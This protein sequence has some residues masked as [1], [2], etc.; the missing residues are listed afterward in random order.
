[1]NNA[2]KTH[3]GG[4]LKEEDRTEERTF[5]QEAAQDLE[6]ELTEG[7]GQGIGYDSEQKRWVYQE[8]RGGTQE[9]IEKF[10]GALEQLRKNKGRCGTCAHKYWD[11]V[12]E[13]M[14]DV[15]SLREWIKQSVEGEV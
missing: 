9:Y 3:G 5:I 13:L 7:T 15:W 12:T 1:M 4:R 10:C 6:K 2:G 14:E 8:C 11:E